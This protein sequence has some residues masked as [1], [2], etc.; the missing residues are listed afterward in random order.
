MVKTTEKRP[1]ATRG[2]VQRQE[3]GAN[4]DRAKRPVR[5]TYLIGQLDRIVKRR[6]NE[7]LSQF[8]LTLPQ[9]TVLSV[10]NARGQMT[11]AQ[12]AERSFI[13]PQSANEVVKNMEGKGWVLREDHP[14]HGRL[15]H[16]RLTSEGLRLLHECDAAIDEVESSMLRG[17]DQ[18]PEESLRG[19]LQGCIGN[20]R[21]L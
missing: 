7:V 21:A 10:L 17:L 18:F 14:T 12:L 19:M 8:G 2:R 13:T 11:N 16:L 6:L 20:L 5:L 15:V 9:F 3:P 1:V 4:P